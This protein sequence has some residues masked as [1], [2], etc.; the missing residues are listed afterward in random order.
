MSTADL[1]AEL[2]RR[3]GQVG[4]LMS[5][6]NELTAELAQ[7]EAELAA[8]GIAASGA[9]RRGRRAAVG[10]RRRHRN[11]ANLE[12]SLAKVLK[13]KTMGVTEVAQ[14]VQAAGYKTTSPNFRTIVNQTL[15]RSSLIKKVARGQYT[16]A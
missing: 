2:Q 4:K 15:L 10:V 3:E 11:D 14:A 16:A 6:H 9:S 5:R 7:I 12:E 13:G 8:L 1:R